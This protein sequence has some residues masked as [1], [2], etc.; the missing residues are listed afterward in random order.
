MIVDYTAQCFVHR[1]PGVNQLDQRRMRGGL[2]GIG[3]NQDLH[4]AIRF[5]SVT[6]YQRGVGGLG[7]DARPVAGDLRDVENAIVSV[8]RGGVIVKCRIGEAELLTEE[9]FLAVGVGGGERQG[10]GVARLFVLPGDVER[11]TLP[12]AG[13]VGE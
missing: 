2:R 5:G 6:E 12:L 1:L 9:R 13:G 10:V 11:V 7:H 4:T 3:G 8:H